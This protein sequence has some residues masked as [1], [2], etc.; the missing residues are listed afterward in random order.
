M[1]KL[2]VSSHRRHPPAS[3]GYVAGRSFGKWD[4]GLASLEGVRG[5]QAGPGQGMEEG[6]GKRRRGAAA[7]GL[8]PAVEP[9]AALP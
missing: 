1:G 6:D 8:W 5:G 4:T 7:A 3:A 2:K 9:R